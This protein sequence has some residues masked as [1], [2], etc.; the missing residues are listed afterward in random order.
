MHYIVYRKQLKRKNENEYEN[1]TINNAE[2]LRDNPKSGR[3]KQA[4]NE[5]RIRLDL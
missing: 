4:C 2:T 5:G 1:W 3:R